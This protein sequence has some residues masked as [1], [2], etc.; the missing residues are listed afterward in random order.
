[1]KNIDEIK[2]VE[3]L[4][5]KRSLRTNDAI[6][7]AGQWQSEE[8][9]PKICDEICKK[10][11]IS[12]DD[13]ILE[14]GCGSGVLGDRL[15]QE[16]KLY[17]GIDISLEMLKIFSKNMQTK[18]IINLFQAITNVVPFTNDTFD[19][20]VINGVTMYFHNKDIFEKTLDEIKRVAK[21]NATLFIGENITPEGY[22]WEFT[23]FKN[24]SRPAQLLAKPY[25]NFRK[26]I[27]AKNSSIAGKWKY[28]HK[29]VSPEFISRYFS[30]DSIEQTKSAACKIKQNI[31]GKNYKGNRRVDF[32]IKLGKEKDV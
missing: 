5:N 14:L 19:V 29:E 25:I 22:F 12:K 20:I 24:L 26:W 3:K 30:K 17:V 7:A 8:Y 1:M 23:W 9:V 31:L 6:K 10:I 4:Y 18:N 21:K 27:A 13:K 32:V 2:H 16:C 15:R 11:R 28:V